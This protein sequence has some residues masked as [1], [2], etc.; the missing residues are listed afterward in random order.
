MCDWKD[1]GKHE[2][3]TSIQGLFFFGVPNKGME[4][5][6]TGPL[7]EIARDEPTRFLV[8]ILEK[9]HET[10]PRLHRNFMRLWLAEGV[11][12]GVPIYSYFEKRLSRVVK[13]VRLR[14]RSALGTKSEPENR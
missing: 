5:A 6:A 2:L 4:R 9:G 1:N 10:L 7:W 3:L 11:C 12:Q 14:S 13:K 8:G